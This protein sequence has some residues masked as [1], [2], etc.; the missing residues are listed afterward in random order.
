MAGPQAPAGTGPSG[1]GPK[2]TQQDALEYIGSLVEGL[3]GIALQAELPFLA[4]L[5][6]VA[7]EEAD[8]Q[9]PPHSRPAGAEHS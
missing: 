2:L 5:L 3:H 9:M 8:S 1:N 7:C 4:Y 6:S